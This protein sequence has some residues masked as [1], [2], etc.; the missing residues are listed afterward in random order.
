MVLTHRLE[1][2]LVEVVTQHAWVLARDALGPNQ[3][4]NH[5]MALLAVLRDLA[6]EEKAASSVV[7]FARVY[8]RTGKL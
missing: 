6:R 4:A 8:P 2:A 7:S 3:R 1:A 5:V